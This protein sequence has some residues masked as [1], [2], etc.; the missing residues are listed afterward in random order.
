MERL[1]MVRLDSFAKM[2]LQ[3]LT[4]GIIV[5]GKAFGADEKMAKL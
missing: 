3:G 1:V 4:S 2:Q 5:D